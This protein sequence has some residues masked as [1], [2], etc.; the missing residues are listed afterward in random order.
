MRGDTPSPS[1]PYLENPKSHKQKLTSAYKIPARTHS[2]A[3]QWFPLLICRLF[4]SGLRTRTRENRCPSTLSLPTSLAEVSRSNGSALQKSRVLPEPHLFWRN[5]RVSAY[6]DR[7]S[8]RVLF[9]LRNC[10]LFLLRDSWN[11][12]TSY[13]CMYVL[14]TNVDYY[15]RLFEF[16]AFP[17]LHELFCERGRNMRVLKHI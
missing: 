15:I 3:P 12:W 13:L 9:R 1:V 8:R 17:D 11:T 5:F 2:H 16:K 4:E 10:D 7:L 6:R 14:F